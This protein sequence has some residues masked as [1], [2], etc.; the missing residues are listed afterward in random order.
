MNSVRVSI[1]LSRELIERLERL[2]KARRW[3]RSRA[4]EL[5]LEQWL[6]SSRRDRRVRAYVEGYL[7]MPED[8]RTDDGFLKAWAEGRPKEDWS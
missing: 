3:T 1:S 5:A 4:I 6:R 2:R 7:R 8:G